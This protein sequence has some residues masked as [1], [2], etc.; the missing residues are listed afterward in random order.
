MQ[1]SYIF[2]DI[3]DYLVAGQDT[4]HGLTYKHGSFNTIM[5][6]LKGFIFKEKGCTTKNRKRETFTK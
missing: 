1:N 5:R 2:N 4:R 3:N 6:N